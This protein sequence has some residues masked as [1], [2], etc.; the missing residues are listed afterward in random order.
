MNF[1][2]LRSHLKIIGTYPP[3]PPSCEEGGNQGILLRHP[4]FA[5][6]MVLI[7]EKRMLLRLSQWRAEFLG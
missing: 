1:N 6:G 5:I 2:F 4:I 7:C 3:S